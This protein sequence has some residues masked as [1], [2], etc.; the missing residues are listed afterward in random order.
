VRRIGGEVAREIYQALSA[1]SLAGATDPL[2]QAGEATAGT[3][4][5]NAFFLVGRDALTPFRETLTDLA[6]RYDARGF[7]FE[8]TGPWPP[9]HFVR[10]VG[11][12]S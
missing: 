5:L 2:P 7:R 6:N 9:Y 8:F 11:D 12:G 3:A 1:R 10:A 4:V